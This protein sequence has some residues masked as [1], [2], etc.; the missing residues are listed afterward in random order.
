MSGFGELSYV[1]RIYNIEDML[2]HLAYHG[3]MAA[4]IAGDVYH[5]DRRLYNTG[6]HLIVVRGYRIDNNGNI[7]IL[8]N[9]PNVN[10]RFGSQFFVYIE[11]TEA[12][13]KQVWRSVFYVIE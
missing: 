3:P 9:D 11:M 10:S 6:G 1:R 12:R 7:T 4:S 5:L 13:F 8:V 2:Y